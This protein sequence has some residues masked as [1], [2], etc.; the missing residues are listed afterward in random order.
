MPADHLI[1]FLLV[2]RPVEN[3]AEVVTKKKT[4]TDI[5]RKVHFF[6]HLDVLTRTKKKGLAFFSVL[7]PCFWT[8]DNLRTATANQPAKLY[9]LRGLYTFITYIN[10]RFNHM[11]MHFSR[12]NGPFLCHAHGMHA[13]CCFFFMMVDP[14]PACAFESASF[15]PLSFAGQVERKR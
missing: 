1:F 3:A 12:A 8:E 9:P 15:F 6:L 11:Q 10:A 14:K 5:L 4:T 2:D 13:C 7:I